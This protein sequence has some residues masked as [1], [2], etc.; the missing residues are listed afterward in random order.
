MIV[1][2][3]VQANMSHPLSEFLELKKTLYNLDKSTGKTAKL[4]IERDQIIQQ[5]RVRIEQLELEVKRLSEKNLVSDG[6]PTLKCFQGS[7]H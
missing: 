5:Q 1:L 6:W 7:H 3:C 2:N 4:V